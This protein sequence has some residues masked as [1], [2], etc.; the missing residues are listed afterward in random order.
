[1][2]FKS[3]FIYVFLILCAC[4]STFILPSS[5]EEKDAF[6]FNS[7]R[8][9]NFDRKE[10]LDQSK[11][12][13]GGDNTCSEKASCLKICNEIFVLDEDQ[14]DCYELPAPQVDQ[15][16][17]LYHHVLEKKIESLQEINVFDLKVFLN[18]SL[19]PFYRSI[20]TLGPFFAKNF[21]TWIAIDWRVAKVFGEEDKDFLFLEVFLNKIS[22]LP[23]SS[24]KEEIIEGRTFVELAWLKQN[25]PALLWLNTYFEKKKCS[26][27]TKEEVKNCMLA[28]YCLLSP[29][30]KNDVS[31]EIM[32]F[33]GLKPL[34]GGK[35][36]A[37]DLKVFC[38]YFCSSKAGQVYCG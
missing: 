7:L 10:V 6:F 28:Q 13:Y 36:E 34:L 20:K 19:E 3:Y 29:S 4:E 21:L 26:D 1:M 14:K 22:Y 24:L 5:I 35:P 33:K 38:S 37:K 30:L 25:D 11:Q 17:E 15:F 8:K 2:L 32:E 27:L 23:I 12:I 31:K 16:Q 18:L 9:I